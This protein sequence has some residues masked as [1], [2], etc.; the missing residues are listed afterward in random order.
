MIRRRCVL[1]SCSVRFFLK[2]DLFQ[3]IRASF[4]FNITRAALTGSCV[5]FSPR[6]LRSL[7]FLISARCRLELDLNTQP[8]RTELLPAG[9]LE[10]LVEELLNMAAEITSRGDVP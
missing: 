3:V 6:P 2:T 1:F 9:R 4:F 8:D 7:D 5:P 10:T